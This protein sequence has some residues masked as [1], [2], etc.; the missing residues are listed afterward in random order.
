MGISSRHIYLGDLQ[1]H[2]SMVP[3][4]SWGPLSLR[5]SLE[6]FHP[7][8]NKTSLTQFSVMICRL[9]LREGWW[10]KKK[11]SKCQARRIHWSR[12]CNNFHADLQINSADTE[13]KRKVTEHKT[14]PYMH[15]T[16]CISSVMRYKQAIW[17]ETLPAVSSVCISVCTWMRKT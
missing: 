8:L 3:E 11:K 15:V 10:K 9:S 16:G 7:L 5:A 17:Y 12:H 13:E 6:P 1:T 14:H 4:V 2:S